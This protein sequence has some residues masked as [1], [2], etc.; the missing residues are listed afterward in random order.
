MV[1]RARKGASPP[2]GSLLASLALERNAA[3]AVGRLRRWASSSCCTRR[4]RPRK[5]DPGRKGRRT[6]PPDSLATSESPPSGSRSRRRLGVYGR[7]CSNRISRMSGRRLN[8]VHWLGFMP[9]IQRLQ[10]AVQPARG[11]GFHRIRH[12]YAGLANPADSFVITDDF[13][14]AGR[15]SGAKSV[16]ISRLKIGNF[17]MVEGKRLQVNSSDTI[18]ARTSLLAQYPMK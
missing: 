18:P 6:A 8:S 13:V 16:P 12:G 5:A 3:L 1:Q 11:F 15:I 17:H 14:S 4:L 10:I 9:L 2:L 7:E